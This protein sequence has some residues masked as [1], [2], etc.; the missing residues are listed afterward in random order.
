VYYT[1]LLLLPT[2]SLLPLSHR[3]QGPSW[4]HPNHPPLSSKNKY[5]MQ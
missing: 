4:H 3:Q 5:T 2:K 1:L